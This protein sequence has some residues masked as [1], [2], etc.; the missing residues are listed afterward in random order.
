MASVCFTGWLCSMYPHYSIIC[1]FWAWWGPCTWRPL[2]HT[3]CNF[4][5]RLSIVLVT[6][7]TYLYMYRTADSFIAFCRTAW[8]VELHWG[9]PCTLCIHAPGSSNTEFYNET[10]CETLKHV[11][12]SVCSHWA[13]QVSSWEC[14]EFSAKLSIIPKKFIIFWHTSTLFA[15][16]KA[17]DDYNNCVKRKAQLLG[18]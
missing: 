14:Q 18:A 11:F 7:V 4:L 8:V 5:Y 17:K 13:D 10:M 2:Y 12:I 1:L 6:V 9:V 16:P 15:L 3:A